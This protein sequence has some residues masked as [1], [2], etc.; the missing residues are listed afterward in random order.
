M[1]KGF[2]LALLIPLV[3]AAAPPER[4]LRSGPLAK[5]LGAALQQRGLDAVA[6][7]DPDE[8]DRFVAALFYPSAQLLVIS[9]RYAAPTLLE[10]RLA[11]KQ[12]REVYLDLGG[13]SIPDSSLL[14]HDMSADGLCDS[15][16]KSADILYEGDVT[17]MFDADWK[18]HNGS[19]HEYQQRLFDA[20]E[21]YSRMLEVLLAA[22]KR[23]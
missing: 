22:V 17:S 4:T 9:A 2:A 16:D 3:V 21:R 13:A 8:P 6:A 11:Q 5:E 23:A 18:S 19:E 15:R 12:Y 7:R 10:A 1:V 20:D 14:V